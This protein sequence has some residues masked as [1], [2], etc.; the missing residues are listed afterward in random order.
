MATVM[1][2][3][4]PSDAIAIVGCGP[5]GQFAIVCAQRLGAGRIFAV[6]SVESGWRWRANT[7][8]KS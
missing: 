1:A 3:I 8:R 2:E 7:E 4:K 5:V 6:E